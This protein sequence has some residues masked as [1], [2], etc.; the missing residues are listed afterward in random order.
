[1]DTHRNGDDVTRILS[2][3]RKRNSVK[4]AGELCLYVLRTSYG[5]LPT[6]N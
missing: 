3:I 6:V 2:L 5:R 4:N 1:M